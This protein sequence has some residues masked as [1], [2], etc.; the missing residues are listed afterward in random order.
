[1]FYVLDDVTVPSWITTNHQNKCLLCKIIGTLINNEHFVSFCP[2]VT[3]YSFTATNQCS[4][5]G[6]KDSFY[7][8]NLNKF[9]ESVIVCQCLKET[10]LKSWN[11]YSKTHIESKYKQK[12]KYC[13]DCLQIKWTV[14][15]T[16]NEFI[17]H[18]IITSYG[19][20]W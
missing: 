4:Y 20:K 12:I 18:K 7:Y 2:M 3:L 15:N 13:Q 10:Y 16:N 9:Q 5:Y 8:W 1:M 17:R 19:R 6:Q 14:S 11:E